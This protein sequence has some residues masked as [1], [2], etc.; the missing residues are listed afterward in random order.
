MLSNTNILSQIIQGELILPADDRY[1]VARKVYNGMIDKRPSMIIQ[2]KNE[3]DVQ[4]ALK[5]AIEH[6]QPIAIRGGGHSGA[7]FGVCDAGMVIDL[8]YM[9]GV[10]VD[11]ENQTVMV[12]GGATLAEIDKATHPYG[13]AVPT[14]IFSSTGIGGLALGG[15]LGHLTRQYGLTIDNLLEAEII[16]V[17][18]RQV[19]AS[20]AQHEDLF[21]A[22]K[23]GGG[24]FGVVTSFLFQ[25]RPVNMVY[26]GPM[27]WPIEDAKELMQWYRAF[28][29]DAPETVSGFFA[30]MTAP[31]AD[32]FPEAYRLQKMCGIVWCCNSSKETAEEVFRSVRSFKAPA[33]DWTGS[34]PFP[35]LQHMFDPTLPP[36]LRQY[37]K[38]DYMDTLNDEVID[39]HLH[40]FQS[41]PSWQ[42]L[43]HLYPVNGAASRIR[44]EE[45]AWNYRKAKWATVIVGV[46]QDTALDATI[47]TWAQN[48]AGNLR[49]HSAGAGYINFMMDEG[50]GD[51]R[52][53]YG[54]NYTRLSKIKA[55]Y[56][57]AN[58]FRFNQNI[59]PFQGRFGDEHLH[60]PNH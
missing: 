23:G 53:S 37:W 38:G 40:Y 36:G 31:P 55:K 1:D 27:F 11:L 26:G 17:N 54:D 39:L 12:Q 25:A 49:P 48:Y 15:G 57:P 58:L 16:L 4:T 34:L 46:C 41:S 28:I 32:A 22:L 50:E 51:V 47:K 14:G 29:V 33:L 20:A 56:D 24:N 3:A 43:M 13:L 60:L 44:P 2:C 30:L 7:G 6:N 42:S 8:S 59:K 21:W 10:A 52:T 45:T 5:W 9:K 19:K 35:E 18:G